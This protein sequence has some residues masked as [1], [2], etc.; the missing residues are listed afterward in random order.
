[1]SSLPHS[2]CTDRGTQPTPPYPPWSCLDPLAPFQ[3]LLAAVLQFLRHFAARQTSIN[4]HTG[5]CAPPLPPPQPNQQHRL[6][7]AAQSTQNKQ[8]RRHAATSA[9][10]E[11]HQQGFC[12]EWLAHPLGRIRT[13]LQA[14]RMAPLHHKTSGSAAVS[15]RGAWRLYQPVAGF[16]SLRKLHHLPLDGCRVHLA[17]FPLTGHEKKRLFNSVVD[18][19]VC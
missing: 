18:V 19:D 16:I 8:L 4:G 5:L 9:P 14:R 1:M 3:P 17:Q 13:R 10:K 7:T 2:S 15:P 11:L 12:L 6:P